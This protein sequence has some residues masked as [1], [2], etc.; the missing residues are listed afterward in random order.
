LGAGRMEETIGKASLRDA[1][2]RCFSHHDCSSRALRSDT[3]LASLY[4]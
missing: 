4:C 1:T 2:N 3:G